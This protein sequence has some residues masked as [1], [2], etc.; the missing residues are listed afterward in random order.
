METQFF[1]ATS[2]DDLLI[3]KLSMLNNLYSGRKITEIYG[4]FPISVTGSGRPAYRLPPVSFEH[5]VRHVSLAHEQGIKF[6]YLMNAPDFDGQENDRQWVKKVINF[7]ARLD[8]EIKVDSLT[9]AHPFLIRL[10]KEKFPHLKV[11][12]SLI[13]GVATLK[14][15]KEY[16]AM[17][18]DLV[19]L[20][21]HTINRNF[22]RLIGIAEKIKVPI[23]L[24][25]NIPCL[26]ACPH[27]DTHYQF[28]GQ[29]SRSGI[30]DKF[31]LDPFIVRCSLI[32]LTDPVQ[33][34]R[35]PFI[36]PEDI[37]EYQ[38][39]GIKIFKL[40]DRSESTAF[41]LETADAYL[42]GH[43]HSD[44]F[45]LI[46]RGG[47]KFKTGIKNLYPEVE[48]LPVPIMINNDQLTE[49]NFFSR[50]RSLSGRKLNEFYREATQK[51]VSHESAVLEKLKELLE[52][53]C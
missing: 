19:Y 3:I 53:N 32:Y 11:Y 30:E 38:K 34:L 22:D 37:T 17:G 9:I 41:L 12:L 6:N 2:W 5:A 28:F 42:S 25:A 52:K 16:E 35:S 18:V 47:N 23:G 40:S 14:K 51:C 20:N 39:M 36:R 1:L 50:L 45:K 15:A 46:F 31:P 7:V 21:P 10:V 33:L 24:Y 44:L 49:L 29:A 43:Y 26:S 27:R 48:N 8:K 13:A 4:S